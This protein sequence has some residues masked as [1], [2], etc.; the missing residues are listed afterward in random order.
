MSTSTLPLA[1]RRSESLTRALDYL[2]L[3]KPRIG[4]F[5]ALVVLASCYV[6]TNGSS[7]LQ[8]MITASLGTLLVGA[9]ASGMN[10]WLER[11]LDQRMVRTASR[12]VASGRL[13][14]FEALSFVAVTMAVGS[15]LLLFTQNPAALLWGVGTW[16]AYVLIYTPLKTISSWNTWFGAVA[17]A[18]PVLIGWSATG[19]ELNAPILVLFAILVV[20][21]LPH[22][23]A[24]A[25][26]YRHDY[27]QAGHQMA[28]VVDKTGRLAAWQ[29]ICFAVLLIVLPLGLFAGPS[30]T[31]VIVAAAL[32]ALLAVAQ[33]WFAWRFFNIQNE[34]TSRRLLLASLIYL[35]STLPLICLAAWPV[36]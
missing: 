14:S 18:M 35:P 16:A 30:S 13:S 36:V 17:G 5:V 22:F 6:A 29:A 9:S 21:Q 20:W 26:I 1:R 10:H 34:Q 25:W 31:T 27:E 32:L 15:A 12:P 4:L 11:K 19:A 2:E 23:M 28:T 33:C 7:S 8:T 24:I 3:A